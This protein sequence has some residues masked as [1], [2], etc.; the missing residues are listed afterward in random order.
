MP[1]TDPVVAAVPEAACGCAEY[2][3]LTRR[4]LF[5][6]GAVAAGT[7]AVTATFGSTVTE[8]A[9]AA[10]R[11]APATVVVLSLRGAAD[12][13]SLVVPHADAAYYDARPRLAVPRASLLATDAQFGLHP[14][15]A[16]L[17][18]LWQ[19]GRMAAVHAVGL[20]A[21]NRSHFAAME[22]IEDADPGSTARIGWLNRLIGRDSYDSPLRGIQMGQTVPTTS[23]QGPSPSFATAAVDEVQLAGADGSRL[24]RRRP[25]ALKTV[26][27]RAPGPLGDGAR[28]LLSAVD[29]FQPVRRTA[30]RPRNG[31][32]YPGDDLGRA[33]AEAARTIR[34]D[35]GAEVIT[36]DHGTWDM[37]SDAGNL[38]W[39]Q[40][41]SK[42]ES[43]ARGLA[44]FFTDLGGLSSKVTV[45]TVSE[46]GRRVRENANW[47]TD[48]GHG[49]VMFALGAGV[50]GGYHGRWTGLETGPD[51][52]VPVTT[53]F[54]S[55]LS[56]LVVKRFGASS[57]Q[58]FPRFTPETV[59]VF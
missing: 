20:P 12:G 58:V 22:E 45:V 39:G 32:A 4:G 47:G 24:G 59:G 18:G 10:T 46:F 23:L 33:L 3:G 42:T 1:V 19:Q 29:D 35:V 54:R 51:A 38:E 40:M 57:A 25:W 11:S 9:F 5:R 41:A 28:A 53:D 26:W 49:T 48:H 43:L 27:N 52:D 13:L 55:V 14:S 56:E 16:P 31:A 21:P 36:V 30:E 6:A 17:L 8:T 37:H 15:L 7:G 50:R 34:A 2:A 44:A